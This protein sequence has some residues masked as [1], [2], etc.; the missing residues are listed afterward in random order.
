ML[1][2][3]KVRYGIIGCRMGQA[4]MGGI[5][6]SNNSE[7]VS[8]CDIGQTTLNAAAKTFGVAES[9]CCKDYKEMIKRKDI[10]AVVVATPDQLHE[11]CTIAALEEG[12]HVLCEKPMALTLHECTSMIKA[13]ERTGKKLMVGQVCRYAPGFTSAKQLIDD[14]Q[15][16]ELFLVESEYAHDY[17]HSTG[18]GNW[19]LDPVNLR[20][21]V[22]GGGCHAVDLLRWIAGNPS[23]VFA[24]ANRKVLKTWPV[25]DC[26]VAIL[27]FPGEVIGKVM[28]SV[29]CKREYTMRSV[30]YGTK[31]TIIADNTSSNI[32]LYKENIAG[33]SKIFQGKFQ[34]I[35]EQRLAINIPVRVDSHNISAEISEFSDAILNDQAV[36]TDGRQGA[37]TVAVCCGIVESVAKAEKVRIEYDS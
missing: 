19:R 7:L 5:K 12:K 30:F 13:S 28:V 21:P 8:I 29:G 1:N 3:K 34:D 4:H 16:G 27:K 22:I 36:K 18:V 11:E 31:G 26:T 35:S 17:T 37:N 9:D 2:G 15:I 14:G 32:T 33:D 6:A 24:Y 25:D 10:D 23:E 20:H